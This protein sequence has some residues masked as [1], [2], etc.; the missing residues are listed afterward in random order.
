M[1]YSPDE[2]RLIREFGE[3]DNKI[4]LQFARGSGANQFDIAIIGNSIP[5]LKS[6]VALDL[7][8]SD[9]NASYHFDGYSADM[10]KAPERLVLGF[11]GDASLLASIS[12]SQRLSITSG[13]DYHASFLVTGG[14]S[15]ID[16]LNK[17]YDELLSAWGIGP[18]EKAALLVSP[19]PVGG[20]GAGNPGEAVGILIR[21][22]VQPAGVDPARYRL[23][24]K[25]PPAPPS[26]INNWVTSNDYP[27]EALRR[28]AVGTVVVF[29]TLNADGKVDRCRVVRSSKS[30]ILDRKSC[31][32][33]TTRAH[34]VPMRDANAN[35][36]PSTVIERIRWRMELIR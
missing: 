32:V 29:L 34:Y 17:C 24:P 3:G 7:A 22:P 11:D 12:N 30:Q 33:L 9:Q 5:K 8:L 31:E 18:A 35:P 20:P 36:I 15:A 25:L 19:E 10:P 14:K 13:S 27:T 26:W 21:G 2:C 1:D 28:G 6:R 4:T 23:D 16:A